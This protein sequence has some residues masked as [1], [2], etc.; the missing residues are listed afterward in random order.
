M[1]L[2]FNSLS[3]NREQIQKINHV[4]RLAGRQDLFVVVRLLAPEL[5]LHVISPE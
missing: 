1:N 4:V 5:R 2:T 3:I